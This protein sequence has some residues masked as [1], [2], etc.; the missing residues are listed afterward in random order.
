[1]LAIEIRTPDRQQVI[2]SV[3]PKRFRMIMDSVKATSA[4]VLDT[5]M[6][7]LLAN[8]HRWE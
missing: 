6:L 2:L 5:V 1:M 8:P 4:N 3:I 7:P